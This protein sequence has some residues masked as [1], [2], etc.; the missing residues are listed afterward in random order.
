MKTL[1]RRCGVTA[2]T[3]HLH[4]ERGLIHSIRHSESGNRYFHPETEMRLH[5]IRQL[6]A[7]GLSLQEIAEVLPLYMESNDNYVSG[8]KAALNILRKHLADA[9]QKLAELNTLREEI[10][11]S[12]IRLEVLLEQHREE[13]ERHMNVTSCNPRVDK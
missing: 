7:I 12:I 2:R 8:K 10:I 11:R 5:K 9:D 13:G 3:V 1:T 4:E 6:Q